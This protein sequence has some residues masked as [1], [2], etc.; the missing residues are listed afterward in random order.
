MGKIGLEINNRPGYYSNKYG[1]YTYILVPGSPLLIGANVRNSTTVSVAWRPP[2]E[3]EQNGI[4]TAYEVK[5]VS[6]RNLLPADVRMVPFIEPHPISEMR[7]YSEEFYGLEEAIKYR[8]SVTAR[9]SAGLGSPSESVIRL[10]TYIVGELSL[11]MF[12]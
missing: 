10:M 3:I 9:T 2:I 5:F 12:K 6:V 7:L 8:I 1:I 11:T 4:I